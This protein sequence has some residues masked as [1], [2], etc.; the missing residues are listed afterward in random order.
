VF[1]QQSALDALT[2]TAGIPAAIAN[3]KH[4]EAHIGTIL[5][6]GEKD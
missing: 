1:I 6:P 4:R 5:V 2:A 3:P